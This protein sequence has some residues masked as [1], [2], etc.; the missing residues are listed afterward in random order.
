MTYIKCSV[1]EQSFI[2]CC[3]IFQYQTK[4]IIEFTEIYGVLYYTWN[5][6]P[7]YNLLVKADEVKAINPVLMKV[8]WEI[9]DQLES[10][11]VHDLH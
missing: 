10:Y 3:S 11:N 8:E 2:V 1:P 9:E 6:E 5:F 4:I 7:E